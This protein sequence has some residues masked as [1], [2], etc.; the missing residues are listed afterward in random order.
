LAFA[1]AG[2]G[3]PLLATDLKSPR[4]AAPDDRPRS[5]NA[6][7]ARKVAEFCHRQRQICRKICNMHSRF[8]DRFDGCPQSCD[9]RETRCISTACYRWTDPDFI[10]AEK[11]GGRKCAL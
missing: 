8:E 4:E 9:S 5:G 3:A 7:T 11:F 2:A 1:I 6:L 10:I